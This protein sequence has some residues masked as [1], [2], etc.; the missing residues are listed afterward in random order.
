MVLC[1]GNESSGMTKIWTV[2]HSSHDWPDFK[3]K[4]A[5]ADINAVADVRSR[6]VSRFAHFN[7]EQLKSRLNASRIEY[8][9]FGLELGGR[10]PTGGP[11]Q[12][13]VDRCAAGLYRIA[14]FALRLKRGPL[15]PAPLPTGEGS[16][17]SPRTCR[18]SIADGGRSRLSARRSRSRPRR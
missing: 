9:F 6:P 7:R 14:A 4:I 13:P 2:G 11:P 15:T 10:P 17:R 18:S 1:G 12:L 16:A 3:R 5:E 8:F